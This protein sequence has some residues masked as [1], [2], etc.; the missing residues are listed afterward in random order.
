VLLQAA[1]K[2]DIDK[3]SEKKTRERASSNGEGSALVAV[4]SVDPAGTLVVEAKEALSTVTSS[5]TSGASESTT[6][7][8]V[9][10]VE[11]ALIAARDPPTHEHE[12]VAKVD[13][14][15]TAVPAAA[16]QTEPL[17]S[18]IGGDSCANKFGSDGV[19][20]L[21][22]LLDSA[23]LGIF[24]SPLAAAGCTSIE[25]ARELSQ[26]QLADC[27]LK[28]AHGI[29]LQRALSAAGA[30]QKTVS[31]TLALEVNDNQQQ[32]QEQQQQSTPQ[33]PPQF[34]PTAG[35]PA[36]PPASLP[37]E[38]RRPSIGSGDAPPSFIPRRR[39]EGGSTGGAAG[40]DGAPTEEVASAPA[41]VAA[42]GPKKNLNGLAAMMATLPPSAFS[43]DP[44]LKVISQLHS[45]DWDQ[46]SRI[47]AL[48]SV[49]ERA[50]VLMKLKTTSAAAVRY[51]LW[52]E[53][54]CAC[55]FYRVIGFQ[56]ILEL[57]VRGD[58]SCVMT[59]LG[60]GARAAVE[61]HLDSGSAVEVRPYPSQALNCFT[62]LG[63]S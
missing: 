23:G 22:A 36:R 7:S 27:G 16:A 15:T 35:L 11:H 44:G 26:A 56:V 29:K 60:R 20:A 17:S 45:P 1:G 6:L 18:S 57:R 13:E 58:F 4:S 62:T 54:V 49:E 39:A 30:E 46:V 5:E 34:P 37:R 32:Q 41:A 47:L 43:I 50:A 53:R 10:T 40:G 51:M 12:V 33:F 9:A 31:G 14:P 61:T 3:K 8:L 42:V 38:K 52:K 28:K 19:A 55:G 2:S 24:L 48:P 63:S 25:A 21:T 59:M